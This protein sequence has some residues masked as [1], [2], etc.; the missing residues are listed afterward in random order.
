MNAL[1]AAVEAG[2]TKFVVGVGDAAGGSRETARIA[3]RDPDAT[4]DETIAF[5][6]AAS[7]R[8][9]PIA[10]LG[11]G[12]FGPL[13][14]D[15]GSPGYGSITATPKPGWRDAPLLRRLAEGLGVPAAIDTDVNAAALAEA[16]LGAGRGASSLAYVTVGTGIGVGLYEGGRLIHGVGH[17]E[18]GHIL[19]RRH[20]AHGAFAGICPYHGDCLEGLA[21]GPAIE[22]AWGSPLSAL[23]ADHPAFAAQADYLAQLA[24]LLVLVAAP[25]RIVLGGGVMA[26]QALFPPVRARVR[27]LLAGYVPRLDDAGALAETIVPPACAEPP[28]L[29][30]AY[31]LAGRALAAAEPRPRLPC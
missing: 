9:G 18:A 7:A 5:L 20:P 19:P 16:R 2:G 22:A 30:G 21:S 15:P 6:R 24:V 29:L 27:D 3:T 26:Q 8:H 17:P 1:F 10:A 28:G 4:L 31:L 14:L 25:A 13:D 12:S 23:P 11:I